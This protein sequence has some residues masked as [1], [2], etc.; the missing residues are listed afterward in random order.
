M[1]AWSSVSPIREANPSNV[2]LSVTQNRLARL[3]PSELAEIIGEL[4]AREAAAV[5]GQLDDETAA[6]AFEHLDVE[7]QKTIIGDIGTERAADIIEEMDAD[8]AADLLAELPEDRQSEL[9]AEMNDYTAGELRELVK[10]PEDSAGGLMT[11]D[12]VWI[13]PHRTTEATIRKIREIAP[14]SEFIYYLYVLDKADHLLGTISLRTLL[15]ELP[16]AF[17]DRIMNTDTVTVAPDTPAMEV[18]ATIARYDLLAVPVL[19]EDGVMIGI[20]T[21]DDA[22]DAIMPDD[23]AKKLPRFTAR[24][25]KVSVGAGSGN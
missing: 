19:R 23:V 1:I 3:H 15:L 17:I 10:Y 25:H 14:T 20:V 8:D 18:A 7:T 4:S 6:D 21:V 9:L 13:Y 24:H 22:I 11:T 16:T 5:V 12:F 2:R